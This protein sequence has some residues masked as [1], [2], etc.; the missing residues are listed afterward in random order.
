MS[1]L[2]SSR[3]D[4]LV[5]GPVV[6]DSVGVG[7]RTFLRVGGIGVALAAVVAACDNPEQGE[8]GRVGNVPPT[9][10]LP[11]AK[12]DDIVLLRTASSLEHSIVRAYNTMIGWGVIDEPFT[13][14]IQRFVADHE[15]HA[16]LFEQLTADAG[17][18]PW[19]TS[20]PRIDSA[21]LDPILA[22]IHDGAAATPTSK[23]IGPSDD[24]R[25]DALNVSHGLESLDGEA[26]Q[27]MVS[28]LA[29][30]ELRAATIAVGVASARRAAL[31]AL[32]INSDRPGGYTALVA[33]DTASTPDTTV[34]Q[35]PNTTVQNVAAPTTAAPDSEAPAQTAIPDVSAIPS[36]YGLLGPVALVV[37]LGDENGVRLKASLET[38]S[39]NSY[40]YGYFDN[41]GT[42][43]TV[44]P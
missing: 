22:R 13:G 24:V 31:L 21:V 4:A 36:R 7:R 23:L 1:Q 12:V 30:L 33:Q 37:G 28:E 26:C 39:L 3:S 18:K 2:N 17:G 42:T 43:T 10:A 8:L 25:R 32:T 29:S 19:T 15:A 6:P 35:A 14:F 38:P 44:A 11:D 41:A 34:Q 40:V 16:K 9:T 27:A 5:P 20:N